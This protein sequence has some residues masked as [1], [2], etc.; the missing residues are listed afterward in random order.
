MK[1]DELTIEQKLVVAGIVKDLV[2]A[3]MNSKTANH[4]IIS[5][6]NDPRWYGNSIDT[7]YDYLY[8]HIT[9]KIKE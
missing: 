5:E 9:S 3:A 4:H 2:V 6:T 7:L 1:N 8:E